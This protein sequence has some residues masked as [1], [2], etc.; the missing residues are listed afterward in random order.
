MGFTPQQLW[1]MELWEFGAAIKGYK[2]AHGIK[3]PVPPPT[4]AE[5]E[6]AVTHS[7]I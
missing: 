7:R 5:F 3:D 1:Q 6:Y 2:A 4:I